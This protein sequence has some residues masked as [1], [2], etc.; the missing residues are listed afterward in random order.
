MTARRTPNGQASAGLTASIWR[1]L[2][3]VLTRERKWFDGAGW[4]VGAAVVLLVVALLAVLAELQ[5]PEKMLWTGQQVTGTEQQGLVYYRWQG[6]SYSLD[7]PGFGSS[8]AVSVYFN[9]GDPS[10][11]I[12]DNVPDRVLT[13]LFV[14]GPA[15]GAVV[16]LVIGGTRNYRWQRRKLKRAREFRL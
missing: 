14:L 5:V 3:C 11:A 16:L 13:G 6:Q 12:V 7:V 2:S 1:I 15:A 9:P 8:K 4:F 10:Q